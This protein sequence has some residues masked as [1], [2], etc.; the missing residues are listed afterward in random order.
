[1]IIDSDEE[2]EVVT[3]TQMA[4]RSMAS[5][6]LA[7]LF[8]G[9]G[10]DARNNL[11]T[12]S[13]RG[14]RFEEMFQCNSMAMFGQLDV[15]DVDRLNCGGLVV[16][17][18]SVIRRTA[19]EA[20][21]GSVLLFR[22]TDESGEQ[23]THAGLADRNCQEGHAYLPYWMM[24][25]LKL[26]EGALI[27]VRLVSLPKCKLVEFEWQDEAFMDITDPRAVLERALKSYFTLTPGDKIR[28]S[29]NNRI[30]DLLVVRI[31]PEA[32]GGV[33]MLNTNAVVEFRAPPGYEE[34][35]WPSSVSRHAY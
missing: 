15:S 34:P 1:M 23:R 2:H 7:P 3:P 6:S 13:R 5:A 16:L 24:E 35:S 12:G 9:I 33:L 10:L 22:I 11:S 17:P 25:R 28:I 31:R 4:S 20:E 26:E 14:G 32:T 8:Q 21:D 29:Y 30:Y 27:N 18:E 19:G